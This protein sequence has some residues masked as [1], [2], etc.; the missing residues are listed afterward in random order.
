MRTLFIPL[1]LFLAYACTAQ[2]VN[3]VKELN[4]DPS[5]GTEIFEFKEANGTL[6]FS[7]YAA[8]SAGGG[9]PETQLWK[10]KGDLSSTSLL[11]SFSAASAFNGI[12]SL[13]SFDDRLFFIAFD[14]LHGYELWVSDGTAGG[15]HLFMDV[16]PGT[17]SGLYLGQVA[18]W[19]GTMK[20]MNGRL[21]FIASTGAAGYELWQTDGTV[22]GTSV[23]KHIAATREGA[24][25]VTMQTPLEVVGNNLFFLALDAHLKTVLWKSDGTS[26]GTSMVSD[27]RPIYSSPMISYNDRMYFYAARFDSLDWPYDEGFY[28]TDG[29]AGGTIL[30]LPGVEVTAPDFAV[31]NNILYFM[32]SSGP[33]ADISALYRTDGTLQGSYVVKDSLAIPWPLTNNYH[34][35]LSF[36]TAFKEKLYFSAYMP[37]TNS[38]QL[39]QSDGTTQNT[40][41]FKDF[42]PAARPAQL[43][44]GKDRLYFKLADEQRV[45]L[46]STD[47]TTAGTT[48]NENPNANNMFAPGTANSRL[49][50]RRPVCAFNNQILFNNTYDSTLRAELYS[51]RFAPVSVS[52]VAAEAGEVLFPNPAHQ[53]VELNEPADL[54]IYD[55]SGRRVIHNNGKRTDVSSLN[56][57]IYMAQITRNGSSS[58]A[59]FL[60][61]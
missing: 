47:G 3:L 33:G 10:T 57:G 20:V 32:S 59:K 4:P 17:E 12:I 52:E 30:L 8:A 36:L 27:I 55:L 11:K 15:T 9:V 2:S 21:Y 6:F 19:A 49:D 16:W 41:V 60:K 26:A 13:T 35:P 40:M 61:E 18:L 1:F 42:S 38:T 37:G 34:R 7:C 22:A 25:S 43:T 5:F 39:W 50:L 24:V 58:F 53:Y 51:V 44:V 28:C 14:T 23:V 29:T 46:W 31:L 54:V 48:R 45:E 56:P